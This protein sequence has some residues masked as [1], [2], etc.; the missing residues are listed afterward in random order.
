MP[1]LE[2]LFADDVAAELQLRLAGLLMQHNLVIETR[3]KVITDLT[4]DPWSDVG[5][6]EY[7][8]PSFN[9]L[10]QDIV[11]GKRLP[12]PANVR[13]YLYNVGDRQTGLI[14]RIVIEVKYQGVGSPAVMSASEVAGRIKSVYQDVKEYLLIRAGSKDASMKGGVKSELLLPSK[15]P[16]GDKAIHP[17]HRSRARQAPHSVC[18][19]VR[20][21]RRLRILRRL[22]EPV[23]IERGSS[24]ARLP[25]RKRGDT[26]CEQG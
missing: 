22:V 18:R 9:C 3:S 25:A 1:T 17:P 2:D 19:K 15:A 26:S 16:S 12:V 5:G 21:A 4:V 13:P 14:P 8:C 20:L 24:S 10:E 7:L 6:L 11:I 23:Q